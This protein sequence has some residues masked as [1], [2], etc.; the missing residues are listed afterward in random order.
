MSDCIFRVP[1]QWLI[2]C[3][4]PTPYTEIRR[5]YGESLERG[6]FEQIWHP[7]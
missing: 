5:Y 6:G 2:L 3:T 1:T 4:H 7:D